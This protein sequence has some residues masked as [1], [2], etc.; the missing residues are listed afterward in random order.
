MNSYLNSVGGHFKIVVPNDTNQIKIEG[1]QFFADAELDE[2]YGEI[3]NLER[4]DGNNTSITEKK[5]ELISNQSVKEC[6]TQSLNTPSIENI[7]VVANESLLTEIEKNKTLI[8]EKSNLAIENKRLISE[9]QKQKIDFENKCSL[10]IGEKSDLEQKYI[11]IKSQ[12]EQLISD[13]FIEKSKTISLKRKYEE[14]EN[15]KD[16]E[17]KA[18]KFQKIQNADQSLVAVTRIDHL[19]IKLIN[20]SNNRPV[21]ESKIEEIEKDIEIKK[22]QS[23]IKLYEKRLALSTKKINSL[24]SSL[25]EKEN[26]MMSL[27]NEFEKEKDGLN[28]AHKLEIHKRD[29]Q[30]LRAARKIKELNLT[31]NEQE[32]IIFNMRQKQDNGKVKIR[33]LDYK[34]YNSSKDSIFMP[35]KRIQKNLPK[36]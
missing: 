8:A 14:I 23:Q 13:L 30:L 21:V 27:K 10:L 16:A 18:H 2:L 33:A 35:K 9:I 31:N 3:F 17:N 29:A 22:Y 24:S 4:N 5:V 20:N 25:H 28:L 15:D 6:K 1:S 26:E 34:S 19:Q 32:K 36:Q 7:T 11:E 12:N